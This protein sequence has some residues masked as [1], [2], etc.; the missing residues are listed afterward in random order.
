LA[1]VV[2]QPPAV[3]EPDYARLLDEHGTLSG[4]QTVWHKLAETQFFQRA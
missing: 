3:M 1:D 4:L 2:K